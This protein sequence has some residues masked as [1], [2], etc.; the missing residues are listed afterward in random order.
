MKR[1]YS[2]LEDHERRLVMVGGAALLVLVAVLAV[3]MPLNERRDALAQRAETQ[4]DTLAWMEEARQQVLSGR[5]QAATGAGDRG[6]RSL[7]SLIDA[8]AREHELG[9]RLRRAEP[10]GADGVRVWFEGV[11]FTALAGWMESLS[12]RYGLAFEGFN[13][14]RAGTGRVNARLTVN[15]SAEG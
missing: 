14:D 8:T 15:E 9:E 6:G 5:R 4:A 11:R 2:A 3:W 13:I 7:L 1:W 12:E 10:S